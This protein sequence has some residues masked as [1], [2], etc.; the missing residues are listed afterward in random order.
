MPTSTTPEIEATS[1]AAIEPNM[2]MSKGSGVMAGSV[3]Q[4][5]AFVRPD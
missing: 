4:D 1:A 2:T 3:T 5:R